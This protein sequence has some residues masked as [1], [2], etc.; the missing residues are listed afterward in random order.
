MDG[1]TTFLSTG[2]PHLDADLNGGLLSKTLTAIVAK[3]GMGTL[4]PACARVY[5]IAD[6]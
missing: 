4:L 6:A 1:V 5:E 2:W 3:P